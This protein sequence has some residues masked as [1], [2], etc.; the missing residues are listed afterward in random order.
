MTT[1]LKET[2]DPHEETNGVESTEP[3]LT[4]LLGEFADVT[5]VVEAARKTRSAGYKVWDVHS[6]FPIHGIDAVIGIRPTILPWLVLIG[7][8]TGASC[9]FLLQWFC[10]TFDYPIL[11]SA[12]PMLSLPADV[13]IIFEC[14]VLFS[15]LTAV[16]G[17]LALNRLPLL[18]NPLFKSAHFRRVTNDRFFIWIDASDAKFD[19]KS[20]A[21]FLSSAGATGV[22]RIED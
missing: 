5:G 21:E 7:G 20:T 17:M 10:N 11:V 18:Y 19:E 12:K 1:D 15:A 13:P 4:G 9:G 14:A 8:V 3:M 16:F 2:H 22:E 6:P